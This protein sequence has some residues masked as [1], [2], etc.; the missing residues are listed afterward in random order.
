[1]T[2]SEQITVRTHAEKI[3]RRLWE[4]F[5]E[6]RGDYLKIAK[7]FEPRLLKTLRQ[8]ASDKDMRGLKRKLKPALT[9][10]PREALRKSEGGFSV[11]LTSRADHWFSLVMEGVDEADQSE[12]AR[13]VHVF[14]DAFRKRVEKR[15][16]RS[17]FHDQNA[18]IYRHLLLFDFAC[19]WYRQRP[20]FS[21]QV[22][23]LRPGIYALGDDGNGGVNRLIHKRYMTAEEMISEYGE[24]VVPER[25][26][27]NRTDSTIYEVNMLF[28]P[29]NDFGSEIAKILDV[30]PRMSYRSYEWIRTGVLDHE[31]GV[32]RVSGYRLKPFSAPRYDA[33]EDETYGSGARADLCLGIARGLEQLRSDELL[34][35]GE[36]ASP[37]LLASSDMEVKGV[38]TSRG[39]MNFTSDTPKDRIVRVQG[40]PSNGQATVTAFDRLKAELDMGFFVDAFA[41]I[42]SVKRNKQPATATEIEQLKAESLQ[43]IFPVVSRLNSYLDEVV[44]AFA[45]HQ[46]AEDIAMGIIP[47]GLL[48]LVDYVFQNVQI[49]YCSKIHLAMENTPVQ[50]TLNWVDQAAALAKA[51]K[52]EAL[53]Y[54]DTHATLPALARM[55][56]VPAAFVRSTEAV[57]AELKQIQLAQQQAAQTEQMKAMAE[58]AN[59]IGNTSTDRDHLAGRMIPQEGGDQNAL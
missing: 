1:M 18:Y 25:I 55:Q 21:T 56:G 22:I 7:I 45:M 46:L 30:D 38:D 20:D 16:D 2:V 6:N 27:K 59:K 36:N 11:N 28:E 42:E 19:L 5:D 47:Q 12:Q 44:S 33:M 34:I 40:E 9:I 43:Q 26:A 41:A 35:S 14:L 4:R 50:A 31:G 49:R 13:A 53:M 52:T 29:N 10:Y 51:G 17:G 37:A 39:A 48:P 15:M 24:D 58:A 3:A 32:L 23:A 54:I 57:I 8:G